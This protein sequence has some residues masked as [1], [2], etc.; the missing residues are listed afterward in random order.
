MTAITEGV[1]IGINFHEGLKLTRSRLAVVLRYANEHGQV[2]KESLH[3]NTEIRSNMAVAIPNLGRGC[4]FLSRA[5]RDPFRLTS[6]GLEIVKNDPN[7]DHSSTFWLM[8][9]GMVDPNGAGPLFWRSTMLD[10]LRV[11]VPTAVDSLVDGISIQERVVHAKVKLA[12]SKLID[13]Y[14]GPE[15]VGNLG[16]VSANGGQV[17]AELPS[18]PV[19]TGVF[20]YAVASRWQSMH[21]DQVTASLDQFLA[22]SRLLDIFRLSREGAESLLEAIARRGDIELYRSAPPH[23]IVRRWH[24]LSE[25][26]SRIYDESL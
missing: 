8:H 10:L 22:D 4:G 19:S 26:V 20:A 16:F 11:G 6:L 24:D 23:Q 25:V 2:T 14:T 3:D 1:P 12:L 5:S 13:F 18:Y 15:L 21:P 17:I 9:F 7:L